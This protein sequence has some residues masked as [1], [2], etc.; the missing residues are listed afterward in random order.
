MK[1]FQLLKNSFFEIESFVNDQNELLTRF[2]VLNLINKWPGVSGW[3]ACQCDA[4]F[5]EDMGEV[6][7]LWRPQH[8]IRGGFVKDSKWLKFRLEILESY[9]Q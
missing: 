5:I 2:S 9:K 8:N 7:A 3:A 4:K 6:E 1:N